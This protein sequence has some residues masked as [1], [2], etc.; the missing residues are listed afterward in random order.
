MIANAL[1]AVRLVLAV[2]VA[3][4]IARPGTLPPGAILACVLTAIATD[5]LDGIVARRYGTA[6]AG[7][8]L[9]DHATDFVF[10]T[11]GLVAAGVAGTVPLA[12]PLLIVIAFTQYVADSYWLHREKQLRMSALGRWNGM[13][14]FVPLLALGVS[15]LTPGTAVLGEL[16]RA[17]SWLLIASTFASIVDR[18]VAS[19]P[20]RTA[21][22]TTAAA[23]EAGARPSKEAGK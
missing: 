13:L 17:L 23:G 3:W 2:P 16:V 21:T 19:R 20:D 14:Y 11:S 22:W 8:R 1:T 12:L 5:L 7:G 4:G 10:V 18:G 6:S 15:D 9:Y